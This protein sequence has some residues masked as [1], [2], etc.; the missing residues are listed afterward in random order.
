LKRKKVKKTM[1][2][3][4]LLKTGQFFRFSRIAK[5]DRRESYPRFWPKISGGQARLMAAVLPLRVRNAVA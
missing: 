5:R 3:C 4:I 1:F 2:F